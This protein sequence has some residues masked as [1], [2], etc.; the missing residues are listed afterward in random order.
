MNKPHEI[1]FKNLDFMRFYL[2]DLFDNPL[3]STLCPTSFF[4]IQLTL[5]INIP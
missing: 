1:K 2:Y 3:V 4:A 5:I